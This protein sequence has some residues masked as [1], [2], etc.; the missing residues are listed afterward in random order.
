MA[1]SDH[2]YRYYKILGIDVEK[3]DVLSL[4]VKEITS[5]YR[6]AVLR[7][8]PDKNRNDASAKEK[9]L[10]VAE[11]YNTLSDSEK[12][13]E[14]DQEIIAERER[15]KRIEQQDAGRRRF[16]DKLQRS[17]REVA[18]EK[19]KN[20]QLSQMQTEMEQLRRE[21][22]RSEHRRTTPVRKPETRHRDGLMSNAGPWKA[23]PGYDQFRAGASTSFAQFEEHVLSGQFPH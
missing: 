20:E 11:A 16:R 21:A 7:W 5:A 4:S 22:M 9:F 3:V 15:L 12:K 13:K 8:H 10:L 17:E 14:Y 2:K 1:S 6:K 18:G 23:V 19:K